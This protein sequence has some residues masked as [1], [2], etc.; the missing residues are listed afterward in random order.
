MRCATCATENAP[1]SRFCGGCGAPITT[2][3]VV[4]TVKIADDAPIA[5]PSVPPGT[6]V[7][8]NHAASP[9]RSP[10]PPYAGVAPG[11]AGP[12]SLPPGARAAGRSMA[13]TPPAGVSLAP[14]PAP[15]SRPP[16]AA[17]AVRP[18]PVRAPAASSASLAPPTGRGWLVPL[19]VVVD[20]GLAVGGAL[21]LRAGL[22]PRTPATSAAP[23]PAPAAPPPPAAQPHGPHHS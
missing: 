17:P 21:L 3:R 15:A 10:S 6:Y 1:D 2:S 11:L 9:S 23:A 22:A 7:V 14:Q 20:L 13:A 19:L 8:P 5:P 4:P 12:A 16:S 18:A